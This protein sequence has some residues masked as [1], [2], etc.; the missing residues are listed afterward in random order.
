M[1]IEMIEKLALLD[2]D[3]AN[4]LD[5]LSLLGYKPWTY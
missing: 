2:N 3:A 5:V 1:A 4:L